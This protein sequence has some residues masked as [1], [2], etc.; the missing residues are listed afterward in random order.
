VSLRQ[1]NGFIK[2]LTCHHQTGTRQYTALVSFD[3]GT[4]HARRNS[5]IVTVNND[6]SALGVDFT[7]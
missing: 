6:E 5:K 4:I 2:R 7:L 1:S 3:D